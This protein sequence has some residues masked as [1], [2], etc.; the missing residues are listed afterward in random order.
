M[1]RSIKK[2]EY[3]TEINWDNQS[4]GEINIRNFPQIRLDTPIEFGGKGQYPC[5]DE[6]FVS[7][8]G[9]CLLTTLLYFQRKWNL[10]PNAIRISV[11]GT[12]DHLGPEGYRLSKIEATIFINAADENMMGLTKCAE[13]AKE[14]C[15][16][17][18]V[19]EEVIPIK[20]LI[21]SL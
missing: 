5:P 3:K 11:N 10:H 19:L 4:G 9:G 1:S 2:L 17:T 13:L 16:I 18:R 20:I 14:Y 8:I 12:I 21:K 6:L 15:H 7:A